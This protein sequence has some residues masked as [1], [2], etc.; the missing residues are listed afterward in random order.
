MPTHNR[1]QYAKSAIISVLSIPS[2]E[3]QLVV[4][5]SSSTAELEE[6]IENSIK[7]KRLKYIH[8]PY[9]VSMTENHNLAV[10]AA[11]GEYVCLIGDDDTI[12][13]EAISAV[14]WAHANM[15]EALSPVVVANY[16]WPDFESRYFGIRQAS[17]IFMVRRFG[18]IR[19]RDAKRSLRNALRFAAQGTDGLPK[20]YH[21]FVKRSV[22]DSIRARSGAYFHGA[23]PDVS[24]AVGV[25]MMISSYCEINYP[26][27]LPGASGGSNSGRSAM[28]THKGALTAESQTAEFAGVMWPPEIPRFF[29]VETVWAHAAIATIRNLDSSYL[30]NYDFPRLY[31]TCWLRH[32]DYRVATLDAYRNSDWR[33]WREFRSWTLGILVLR[34]VQVAARR[35][36]HLLK[37]ALMPT[38]GGWRFCIHNISNIAEAQ[39]TVTERLQLENAS[40]ADAVGHKRNGKYVQWTL[41]R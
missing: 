6:F 35:L 3:L 37:R 25:A 41:Y 7:D 11:E 34:V 20:I 29:S 22:M 21:G 15:V 12:M 40:F 38:P 18:G 17:T 30:E 14:R 32:P 36:I 5:D 19:H 24:G 16:T 13:P 4:H 27:T 10:G 23:S 33:K 39:A 26:L 2:S 8:Y 31:A 9:A 28:N 1:A